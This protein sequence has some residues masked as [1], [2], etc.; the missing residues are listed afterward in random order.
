M[1]KKKND[2][3][4][5][6]KLYKEKLNIN[7]KD[8]EA[9]N[10]LAVILLQL[11]KLQEAKSS[12]QKAIEINPNYLSAHNNLGAIF[13]KLGELQKAVSSCQKAIE[14]NPN[15]MSAHNNLGAIFY[16][17]GELQKAKN[18]YQKAI[19]INPNNMSAHNNLGAAFYEL[20]E[21]QKAVSSYQKA[22]EINPNNMSGYYNLGEIFRNLKEFQKAANCFEK[23]ET[24]L[25]K[26]QFLECTYLSNGLGNYN[27]LLNIFVKK[28]P[29]NL[30][31]ATLAAYVSKKENIKNIYPF[32]KNPLDYFFSINL[33]DKSEISE[34]FSSKL[35]KISENLESKWRLKPTVKYGYQSSGNLFDHLGL[36]IA[37]LKEK[38]EKQ[39]NIFRKHHN[40]SDD[41]YISRWPSKNELYGWY[42]I[43]NKNGQVKDH[44]HEDGWLSG[45]LYLKVPK[46]LKKKDGSINISLQGFDY[47]KDKSLPNINYSPK[48][49]DLI[50]FPSSALHYTVPFTSNEERHCISFD[51]KPR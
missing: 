46:T 13:K 26:A 17:L 18:C 11:G 23:V 45:V 40:D 41:Y 15:N 2:L 25:G 7:P 35:L 29:I 20:G 39:I 34:G 16:E 24:P 14:I 38:I 21:L 49:F 43:L 27:K 31:I 30:R 10:N 9:C 8:V 12:C 4:I 3:Q 50:F 22:I 32:C 28:D 6:E 1:N 33:K 48:P 5:A 37:E 51:L 44:I 19:E 47:P 36:E 42:V